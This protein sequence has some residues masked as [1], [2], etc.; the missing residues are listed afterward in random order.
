MNIKN[1]TFR[2]D[3]C[4]ELILNHHKDDAIHYIKKQKGQCE[5][6][7]VSIFKEDNILDKDIGDYITIDFQNINDA[8]KRKEIIFCIKECLNEIAPYSFEKVLVVGLGNMD[9]VSDALGPKSCEKILVSSHLFENEKFEYLKGC[10][11]VAILT[12]KVMGQSGMESAKIT[13]AI[14]DLYKPDLVIAIDALATSTI[15]RINSA[16]QINNVGIKPGSGVGN[17][18]KELDKH[19]LGCPIIAIG[20]A[21]VTSLGSL[22]KESLNENVKWNDFVKEDI[23]L[24]L[25]V[26]PKNMDDILYHLSE[27]IGEGLNYF[28][29]PDYENL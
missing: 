2:T 18:R 19:Y 14:V 26:T 28:I 7:H 4:D 5:I 9:V 16:I 29:H 17:H 1:Y 27:I 12:P 6:T 20:V 3:F 8:K 24:N 11:N 25:I 21:T 22:L 13:K 10:R 15:S 23:D